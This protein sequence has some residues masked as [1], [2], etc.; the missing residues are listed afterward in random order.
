[1]KGTISFPIN[2]WSFEMSHEVKLCGIV[3]LAIVL[4]VGIIGTVIHLNKK[5]ELESTKLSTDASLKAKKI[6]EEVGLEKTKE[7][8]GSIPFLR[9]SK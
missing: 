1:M 9:K 3:C 4:S 5:V 2:F 6:S 8:W 7:R